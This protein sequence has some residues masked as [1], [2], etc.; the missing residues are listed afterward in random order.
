MIVAMQET[1]T[2]ADIDNITT[3]LK[4][5]G[6]EVHRSDGERQ[7]VLGI[8]GAT[9]NLDEAQIEA[10]PGVLNAHRVS[11]PYKLV[12]RKFRPEGTVIRLP[13][14]TTI[15][16]K[17]VCV[18]AGPCS[19][20]SREQLFKI[21]EQI[22]DAG[23]RVLRGGAFKPRTSPYSFQ[24]MGEDGL[25]LLREAGDKFGLMV[26]WSSTFQVSRFAFRAAAS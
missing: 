8:V 15:G 22:A 14:G 3:H 7:T 1:A 19:V 17:E 10:L 21:A 12:G 4:Q 20:E 23:A 9:A 11:S 6:F 18:M 5:L 24:G 13:N 16:S 25:K 2:E 26:I